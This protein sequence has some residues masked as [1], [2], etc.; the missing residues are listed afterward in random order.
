VNLNRQLKQQSVKEITDIFNEA[1]SIVV[2][3][4]QGMT[5]S[6]ITD[7]RIKLRAKGANLK[8]IKNNLATIALKGSKSKD[9][10]PYF[11]GPTAVA[12]SNDPVAT[13]KEIVEF[14]KGNEKFKVIA[15]IVE[16]TIVNSKGVEEL[17]KIPSIDELRATIVSLLRAPAVLLAGRMRAPASAVVNV[18]ELFASTNK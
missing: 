16:G 11:V 10:E 7:L 1:T 12:Y 2:T 3:H 13:S 6:E 4:Y 14:A 18:L 8:I 5:V 17:S 9:L 15:G